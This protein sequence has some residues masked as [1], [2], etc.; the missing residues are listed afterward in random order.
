MHTTFAPG[1]Y[2]LSRKNDTIADRDHCEENN[3]HLTITLTTSEARLLF[4]SK[5]LWAKLGFVGVKF[6]ER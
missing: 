5:K 3:V 6:L 4:N 1:A 2:R